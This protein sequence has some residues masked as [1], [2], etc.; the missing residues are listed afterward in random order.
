MMFSPEL[1]DNLYS[2]LRKH[3]ILPDVAVSLLTTRQGLPASR[4]YD[5]R[6]DTSEGRVIR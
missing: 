6:A 2:T 1:P 5:P 3:G 4:D